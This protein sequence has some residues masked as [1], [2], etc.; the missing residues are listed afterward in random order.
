[1][2]T[3]ESA[4]DVQSEEC[5]VVNVVAL[6]TFVW[7]RQVSWAAHK[8]V[9]GRPSLLRIAGAGKQQSRRGWWVCRVR[10]S[11]GQS[12]YVDVARRFRGGYCREVGGMR[13]SS[14]YVFPHVLGGRV[15]W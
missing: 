14:R 13:A 4:T 11:P 9:K 5:E 8:V 6:H 3:V 7:E 10:N 12:R 2:T 15:W 1:M